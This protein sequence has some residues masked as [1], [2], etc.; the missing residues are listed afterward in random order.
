LP[1]PEDLSWDEAL[2]LERDI[3]ELA[4]A[5]LRTAPSPTT[6]AAFADVQHQRT[7]AL[8]GIDARGSAMATLEADVRRFLAVN[9]VPSADAVAEQIA[10]TGVLR[11][12][13]IDGAVV[14]RRTAPALLIALSVLQGALEHMPGSR[15]TPRT[16]VALW[17]TQGPLL[18]VL[19]HLNA[20][21][22]PTSPAALEQ[23]LARCHQ[24]RQA[25][26]DVVGAIR[27]NGTRSV[28]A[29][30]DELLRMQRDAFA[31]PLTADAVA[32][33]H[34]LGRILRDSC[35]FTPI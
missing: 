23:A 32:M 25:L 35:T 4:A 8:L 22:L 20:R 30:V 15:R 24:P 33:L 5:Q 2:V 7:C 16:T 27:G 34:A 26:V 3:V 29:T 19:A 12:L 10:L 18:Y 14:G 13:P 28:A 17:Q 1:A 9:E 31:P 6:Y 21:P 11:L